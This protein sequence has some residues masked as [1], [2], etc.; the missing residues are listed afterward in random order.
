MK[1]R[2][3]E[4]N[5]YLFFVHPLDSFCVLIL[6]AFFLSTVDY[7]ALLHPFGSFSFSVLCRRSFFSVQTITENPWCCFCFFRDC[8]VLVG[9]CE[10]L[11]RAQ[12]LH[13]NH[14]F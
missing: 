12:R 2:L 14:H 1:V 8:F 4:F 11:V 5:I 13:E 9:A 7:Y 6:R 10:K 3:R